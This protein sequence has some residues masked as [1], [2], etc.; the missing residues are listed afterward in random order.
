MKSPLPEKEPSSA[1]HTYN[2]QFIVERNVLN[3]YRIDTLI[4]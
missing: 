1:A 2:K 4:D 3:L